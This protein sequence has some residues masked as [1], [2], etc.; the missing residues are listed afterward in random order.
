MLLLGPFRRGASGG[1]ILRGGFAGPLG[2]G[3]NDTSKF[4]PYLGILLRYFD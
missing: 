2:N 3:G 4:L 1:G